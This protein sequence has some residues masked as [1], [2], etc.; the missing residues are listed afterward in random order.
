MY[1]YYNQA[2]IFSPLV[3]ILMRLAVG[4]TAFTFTVARYPN[5]YRSSLGTWRRSTCHPSR[6]PSQNRLPS[7]SQSQSRLQVTTT[8]TTTTTPYTINDDL[9]PPTEPDLLTRTIR[10]S[11][12]SLD[13]FLSKKPIAAHTQTAFDQVSNLI[14][15]LNLELPNSQ[16]SNN[17]NNSNQNKPIILDSGC[18]TARSTLLLAE[19]YPHHIVVG[20]DRSFVRLV[21]N[22]NSRGDTPL[23]KEEPFQVNHDDEEAA[24]SSLRPYWQQVGSNAVIVR[25]ELMD[26]WR[27][28]LANK[29]KNEWNVQHHYLLYPNPYPTK[30]RLKQRF[31]AHSSFPILLQVGGEITIRSNWKGYLEEFAHSV[32][33]ADHYYE[34]Q[35]QTQTQTQTGSGNHPTNVARPYAPSARQGPHERTDKTVAW[36]NFERKYDNVGEPTYELLLKRQEEETSC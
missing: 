23:E 4:S 19:R 2:F 17:T 31:Y 1:L 33:I 18:G 13:L 34:E 8:T 9:C 28:I 5:K 30:A 35:T 29:N 11:C 15:D 22:A 6:L 20:V 10:K 12:E 16:N 21:R 25:A 3:L 26:F 27:L 36:T 32:T 24:S 14:L 7:H